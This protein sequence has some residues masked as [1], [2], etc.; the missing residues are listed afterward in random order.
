MQISSET[1]RYCFLDLDLDHHRRKLAT[2]AAFVQACDTRYGLTSSDLR[3]LGGSEITRLEE[4]ILHNDHEWSSRILNDGVAARPPPYGNRMIL[5]LFWEAA[6]LACENFA[7]LC[8]NG[9]LIPYSNEKKIKPAPIGE[10]G[11]PMTY[12]NCPVHRI[13]PGF[14]FQSGDFVKNNGSGGESIYGKKFKDERAGLSLK[15]SKR[16]VLSMGNSGKNSNTSQFF[17]CFAAAPQCDGKH[18]IFGEVISGWPVL[19]AIETLGTD[20]GDPKAPVYITDCGIWA[21]FLVPAAGYWYDQPDKDSFSGVSPVFMVRPRVA[22][23]APNASIVDRFTRVLLKNCD[24]TA[25]TQDKPDAIALVTSLLEE[26]AIDIVIFAPACNKT[27]DTLPA[28]WT[29]LGAVLE[30]VVLDAKP[31][32]APQIIRDRSWLADKDCW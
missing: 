6:P 24:I 4:S 11:K 16:G 17:I 3:K 12:R 15:H 13:I 21:P 30:K 23:V 14:V 7:T 2:A 8:A 20:S 19:D 9:S 22:I 18:T 29:A 28:S 32:N 31:I 1:A 27:I 5:K 25:I 10:S 26:F